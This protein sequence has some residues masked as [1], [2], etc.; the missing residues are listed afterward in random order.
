MALNL[1]KYLPKFYQQV[2]EMQAL[3]GAENAEFTHLR[4]QLGEVLACSFVADF[5]LERLQEWEELF[6]VT[7]R[8]NLEQRQMVVLAMIK[9]FGKFNE[10]RIKEICRTFTGDYNV[11]V[12]LEDFSIK[13]KIMA[14]LKGELFLF[15]DLER[16][17]R[18]LIPAHLGLQVERWYCT[19]QDLKEN[20]VSWGQLADSLASWQEVK[21]YVLIDEKGV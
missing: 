7:P 15:A 13:V 10:E 14:P 16:T 20:Y 11:Q 3:T 17:L 8:G 19:W 5:S 9:G 2:V 12:S 6:A 18:T 4:E 21:E 1:L